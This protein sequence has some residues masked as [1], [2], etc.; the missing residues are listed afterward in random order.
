MVYFGKGKAIHEKGAY[1]YCPLAV[2]CNRKHNE[3]VC[4]HIRKAANFLLFHFA[5]FGNGP[6]RVVP[7]SI[8]LLFLSL[9]LSL[10]RP[11]PSPSRTYG[12]SLCEYLLTSHHGFDLRVCAICL[13]SVCVICLGHLVVCCLFWL[14]F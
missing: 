10:F 8:F 2:L 12:R 9:S 7:F 1:S 13:C 14:L 4:V 3:R 5:F 11:L 6:E